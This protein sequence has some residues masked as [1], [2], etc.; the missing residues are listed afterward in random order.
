VR[1][2]G[3]FFLRHKP[4]RMSGRRR[5]RVVCL[6][7]ESVSEVRNLPADISIGRLS[8]SLSW[9][10]PSLVVLK[11]L[12]LLAV[13]IGVGVG[14]YATGIYEQVT[15]ESV[16]KL[17]GDAGL[18]GPV[19]FILLFSLEGLGVPGMIFMLTAIVVWP[20][21]LAFLMNWLGAI[22]AGTV[23]FAYARYV[24]R[25][26]V[27][28]HLPD[29]IKRFE[30]AIDQRGIR[31]VIII[32][33]LFFL[34]PPAHWA[35]GLSPVAF[36]DFMIGS[37]VGFIPAMLLVSLIGAPVFEWARKDSDAIWVIGTVG[38]LLGALGL[39]A[40]RRYLDGHDHAPDRPP[41]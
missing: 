34:A 31:T 21:W 23:G 19:V 11:R 4:V 30:K 22:A 12:S 38:L 18:L 13:L 32:R 36:R 5:D 37:A 3:R 39:W 20:P 29:R 2:P 25:D 28:A 40:A 41:E 27:A 33:L 26:W 1:R 10:Y 35:L 24:G 16:R 9:S 6:R 14:I 15:V 7:V 8:V 17:V